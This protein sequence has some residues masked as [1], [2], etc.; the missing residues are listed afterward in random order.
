MGFLD[1]VLGGLMQ[2]AGGRS[3]RRV[4]RRIGGKKL[5][6][7][8]GLAAADG[9]LNPSTGT[10]RGSGY[11]F[12]KGT[13]GT[14]PDTTPLPPP[15]APPPAVP[16]PPGAVPPPPVATPPGDTSP[17][18]T[19]SQAGD[20]VPVPPLPVTALPPLAGSAAFADGQMDAVDASVE[21]SMA[22]PAGLAF[23]AVRTM[24]A[25][26]LS[27]GHLA[28][29]ERSTLERHLGEA[30]LAPDEVERIHKDLVLP[31]SVAELA[32]LTA[33]PAE[34]ELLYQLAAAVVAADGQLLAP[35]R[36]WLRG[37]AAAFELEESVTR[38]L[39]ADILAEL[40]VDEL[41]ADEPNADA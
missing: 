26:A 2:D 1:K 20:G 11:S 18:A 37:L 36:D 30:D 8:G 31:A 15:A 13:V 41:A 6:V 7:A 16:P 25:A 5:L 34:R 32:G 14:P 22:L 24:V 33:D 27:D 12:S 9:L 23:A 38:E 35:E 19:A 17:G 3:A 28:A 4:L 29:E 40:Q 10:P 39:E 21:P